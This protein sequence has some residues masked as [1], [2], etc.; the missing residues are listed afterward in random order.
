[1]IKLSQILTSADLS[2]IGERHNNILDEKDEIDIIKG[3]KPYIL[4]LEGLRQNGPLPIEKIYSLREVS[5]LFNGYD[6]ELR[7]TY[8]RS[9][10]ELRRF[11][12]KS[13]EELLKKPAFELPSS[14]YENLQETLDAP[15]ALKI[16]AKL[17]KAAIR[18]EVLTGHEPSDKF[19]DV[20]RLLRAAYEKRK[21]A[22]VAGL[23]LEDSIKSFNDESYNQKREEYMGN[24]MIEYTQKAKE[25]GGKVV[26]IIGKN[27]LAKRSQIYPILDQSGINYKVYVLKNRKQSSEN[28]YYYRMLNEV[29]G[30]LTV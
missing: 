12:I 9:K 26:A 1:M 15:E 13:F 17:F 27:H 24:K 2:I 14:F 5:E 7:K 4:A 19:T 23:D 16:A 25:K 21:D 8:N 30:I 20:N 18:K 22:V 28:V 29:G 11:N 6:E 3:T 10:K